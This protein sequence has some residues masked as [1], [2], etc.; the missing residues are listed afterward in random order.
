MVN[1]NSIRKFLNLDDIRTYKTRTYI[2]TDYGK[3]II[4]HGDI[5]FNSEDNIFY[6]LSDKTQVEKR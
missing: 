3:Q 5:V 1:I 2:K 6:M 4:Y